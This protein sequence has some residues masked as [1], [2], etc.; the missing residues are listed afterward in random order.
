MKVAMLMLVLTLVGCASKEP[1]RVNDTRWSDYVHETMMGCGTVAGKLAGG[2][3]ALSN[4][5]YNQC[6]RDMNVTL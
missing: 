4:A 5:L 2:N 1:Q 6:L 3:D